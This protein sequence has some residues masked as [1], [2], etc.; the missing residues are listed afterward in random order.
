MLA[1]Q[2]TSVPGSCNFETQGQDWTT[3]C[4]F[5]QDP[6][7]EFDWLIGNRAVIEQGGPAKDHTP[8]LFYL[9][10]GNGRHFLYVNSS[11]KQEGDKARIITTRY[12]P[13]SR[14]ICGLRFWFWSSTSPKV[15]MLK[16]LDDF[17]WIPDEDEEVQNPL[18]ADGLTFSPWHL[19]VYTIEELGMDILMWASTGNKR[20]TWTY[21]SVVLSSNSPFQVAFE[22]EVGAN[23]VI[24]FALDDIS[25][26]PECAS[27]GPVA[28]QPPTCGSDRFTCVY[29]KQCVPLSAQC[30]GVEDC[31]DGT[32]EKACPTVT[33]ATAPS[34]L[35]KETEFPCAQLCIPALLRCDGV[36]DCQFSEDEANCCKSHVLG[37]LHLRLFPSAPMCIQKTTATD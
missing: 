24:E 3:A 28:P 36:T 1:G 37:Q 26:T 15:G 30:D 23:A 27:G 20:D 14:D 16:I 12:F 2:Y 29:V 9:P 21:A 34:R 8:A 25:F 11:T 10:K 13:A 19:Q 31:A 35:C 17:Y 22:A 18:R 7:D 5:T 33:P 32:D 6:G 4:K